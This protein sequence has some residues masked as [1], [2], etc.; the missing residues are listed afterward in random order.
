MDEKIIKSM[1]DELQKEMSSD[2]RPFFNIPSRI[3]HYLLEWKDDNLDEY[4]KKYGELRLS[5][6]TQGQL[7]ALFNY[8]TTKD[9]A[10][11]TEKQP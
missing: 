7:T 6:M 2:D 3:R 9:Y 4:C 1:N 8:A 5:Q 10:K 11:L